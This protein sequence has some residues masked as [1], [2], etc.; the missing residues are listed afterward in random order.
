MKTLYASATR[1]QSSGDVVLKVVNVADESL[2]TTLQFDGVASLH[3]PAEALVLTSDDPNDENTLENPTKVVPVK[4]Q[5]DV[6]GTS[7]RTT[8]AGNSVTV[9]RSPSGI[10]PR[11][12]PLQ[13]RP[14]RSASEGVAPAPRQAPVPPTQSASEGVA[15]APRQAP[16]PPPAR[17]SRLADG[18]PGSAA[19]RRSVRRG[20]VG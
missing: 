13:S 17:G 14:T 7:L 6:Q 2:D 5:I 8:F 9:L 4:K 3:S 1:A 19:P 16:V 11:P 18:H 15:P 12:S 20:P 10:V